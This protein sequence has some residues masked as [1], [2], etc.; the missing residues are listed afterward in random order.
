M[1][2]PEFKPGFRFSRFDALVLASGIIGF[3]FVWSQAR[4]ISFVIGFAVF[5][6]FLFC[7]V[8]RIAR[9]LE[10]IWASIFVALTA[11]T[12]IARFPGWLVTILASLAA[13]IAVVA[14]ELTKPSYH[15][16]AWRRI[17]PNLREWWDSIGASQF[18]HAE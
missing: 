15:G 12:V 13:T 2:V 1:P 10:L 4:W 8:F 11:C 16:V 6:F 14:I 5:H 9:N 3:L 7:N 17:N 18:M